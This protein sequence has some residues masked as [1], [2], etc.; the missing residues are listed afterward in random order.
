[1]AIAMVYLQLSVAP[2]V[3]PLLIVPIMQTVRAE[4]NW[5]S[6]PDRCRT[7]TPNSKGTGSAGFTVGVG[8]SSPSWS[9]LLLTVPV[10][11]RRR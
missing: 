9:Q 11:Y 2:S 5:P 8:R 10:R 7:V 4:V 3:R 1:M 6:T